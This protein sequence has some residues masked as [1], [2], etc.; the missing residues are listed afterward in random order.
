MIPNYT[1]LLECDGEGL[2][3]L[4]KVDNRKRR[5]KDGGIT[6]NEQSGKG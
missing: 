5:V 2:L 1:L 4:S 3:D 6:A